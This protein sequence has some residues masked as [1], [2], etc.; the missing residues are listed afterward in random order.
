MGFPLTPEP[1]QLLIALKPLSQASWAGRLP[2]VGIG[3]AFW[4]EARSV[5]YLIAD[6]YAEI[7]PPDTVAPPVEPA[8]TVH[9]SPGFGAGTSSVSA[10][11]TAGLKGLVAVHLPFLER[12]EKIFTADVAPEL[13][14]AAGFLKSLAGGPPEASTLTVTATQ[15][16][17]LR[18]L[19]V[20]HIPDFQ[21]VLAVVESPAVRAMLDFAKVLL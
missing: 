9:G 13:G 2:A 14:E 20:T 16:Q 18:G 8:H 12:A 21:A 15:A 3:G 7:A 5:P 4:A 10:T 19:L 1:P 6:G 11:E 17:A